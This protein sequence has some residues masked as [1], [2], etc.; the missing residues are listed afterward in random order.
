MGSVRVTPRRT[1]WESVRVVPAKKN[2]QYRCTIWQAAQAIGAGYKKAG[3]D[4]LS[5]LWV[6]RYL[7]RTF[8]RPNHARLADIVLKKMETD[9]K[10][11]KQILIEAFAQ[12]AAEA[13]K[14]TNERVA[15]HLNEDGWG[16]VKAIIRDTERLLV[17]S[18]GKKK[19]PVVTMLPCICKN[20]ECPGNCRG[21]CGCERC[22]RASLLRNR[23]E[24]REAAAG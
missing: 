2:T 15:A 23:K 13:R 24:A 18:T 10:N 16:E 22:A 12:T 20:R 5:H 7:L 8:G 21:A 3:Q 11:K 19:D 1:I 4:H 17:A 6:L 14:E 9:P